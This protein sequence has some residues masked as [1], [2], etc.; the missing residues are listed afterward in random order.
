MRQHALVIQVVDGD[1]VDVEMAGGATRRVRLV[2]I[3]TP[4]VYD[5]V[6][7]GGKQA[8]AELKRLLSRDTRVTLTSD[9]TQT[10]KDQYGR[11][12]RY[13]S[14][15]STGVDINRK[16]VWSGWARVYVYKDDPFQRA[17]SYQKAERSADAHDRGIWGL[18]H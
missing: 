2:G 11:L 10:R 13:V 17:S 3:D 5:G 8:S 1:T 4:E 14:K 9:P 12:L 18:C 7:C 6:E 16:Q 15:S